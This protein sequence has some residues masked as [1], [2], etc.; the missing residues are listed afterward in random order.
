M[1]LVMRVARTRTTV[2][3]IAE[4]MDLRGRRGEITTMGMGTIMDIVMGMGKARGRE[5]GGVRMRMRKCLSLRVE[6]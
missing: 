3:V 5:G 1:N 4:M 6:V 2:R